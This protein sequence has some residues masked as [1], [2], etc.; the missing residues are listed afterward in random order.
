MKIDINQIPEE[1]LILAEDFPPESLDLDTDCVKFTT[2]LKVTVEATKITNAVHLHLNMAALLKATCSRCLE[3]VQIKFNKEFDLDLP[4][5]NQNPLVNL[6]PEIREEAILDYP[7]KPLCKAD[8][9][10]LCPKCGRN[11]NEGK[12][13][14]K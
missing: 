6:D 3:A 1:G 5:D 10:G 12:C 4:A 14:C 13:D 2:P 9:Q 8:C 7:V 11:L